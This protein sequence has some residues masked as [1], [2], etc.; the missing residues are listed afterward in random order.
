MH[1]GVSN[2]HGIYNH[3]EYQEMSTRAQLPHRIE[4]RRKDALERRISDVAKSIEAKLEI[5]KQD[6]HNLKKKLGLLKDTE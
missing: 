4:K 1:S 3:E 5:A 2:S 6:I